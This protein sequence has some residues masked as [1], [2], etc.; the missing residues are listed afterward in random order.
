MSFPRPA[1]ALDV[2]VLRGVGIVV[3]L[4]T[5]ASLVACSH[6]ETVQQPINY[7]HRIH[8]VDQELE[9]TDCHEHA[10]DLARATIPKID[11]CADCHDP[12]SPL[13]KSPEEAKLLGYIRRGEN[14]P[15][16]KVYRVPSHVYFS[17]RRHTAIGQ[18]ECN[19]CHGEMEKRVNAVSRQAVPVKMKTCLQ[20]H[21]KRGVDTDCTRCHR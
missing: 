11:V 13:S 14:V 5:A 7:N 6:T 8:V 16:C 4:I 1:C 3:V 9:C 12:D 21:R 18:I 2:G 15:W 20:C 10:R 17:H 19:V